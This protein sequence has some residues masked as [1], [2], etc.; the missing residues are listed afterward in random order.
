[1]ERYIG[2]KIVLAEPEA[3]DDNGPLVA[4]VEVVGEVRPGYRVVYEDGYASWS[5]KATFERAYRLVTE[6]ELALLLPPPE[7]ERPQ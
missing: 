5:P 1:M 2:T 6:A 7:A 3:R 4:G